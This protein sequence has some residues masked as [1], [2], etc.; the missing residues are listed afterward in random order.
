MNYSGSIRNL[1]FFYGSG[2]YLDNK[3]DILK[4]EFDC[5]PMCWTCSVPQ[6]PNKCDN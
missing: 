5:D 1:I 2:S 4:Y 3:D 6:V